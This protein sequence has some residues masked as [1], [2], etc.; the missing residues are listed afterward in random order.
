MQLLF[1]PIILV[2]ETHFAV[3]D[4]GASDSILS[5]DVVRGSRLKVMPLKYTTKVMVANGQM[6]NVDYFVRV[7]ATVGDLHL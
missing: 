6:L 4:S 1:L 5:L 3:L 2:K 7:R